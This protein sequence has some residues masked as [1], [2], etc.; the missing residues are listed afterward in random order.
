MI[1]PAAAAMATLDAVSAW[2][3]RARGMTATV[4][5]AAATKNVSGLF[6]EIALKAAGFEPV[7]PYDAIDELAQFRL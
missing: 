2:A 1:A 5:I 3:G 6:T 7:R 4:A